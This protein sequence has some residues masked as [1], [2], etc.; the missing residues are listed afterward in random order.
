MIK[1]ERIN[2]PELW[3]QLVQLGEQRRQWKQTENISDKWHG[4][5]R[6]FDQRI[7]E[8]W[9]HKDSSRKFVLDTLQQFPNASVLDIGAGSGAWVSLMAPHARS[10]TAL[11]PSASML[12]QVRTRICSENLRN[13]TVVEGCWPDVTVAEHDIC[14]CSHAMYGTEDF[15]AF[16]TAMQRVAKKR[17]ILLIRATHKDHLMAQ[18]AEML[19]DHPYDSPNFQVAMNILWGMQI[20][21]NV[22]M[23]ADHLWKPW[24][25]PTLQEALLEMKTRLGLFESSAWDASLLQLLER[26]LLYENGEYV[27]PAAMCT[28]LIYWDQ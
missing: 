6:E 10:I 4:R 23:E 22:I 14:F 3:K 9:Q 1:T 7:N 26:N 28:A 27:W 21:P 25:H 20:F 19:W 12:E 8:R 11:D 24:S 16:I 2:Y 15:P 18:A 13:V 5:A 17:I